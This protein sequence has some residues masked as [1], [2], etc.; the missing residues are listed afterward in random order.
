M[1]NLQLVKPQNVIQELQQA[2]WDIPFS[3]SAYQNTTFVLAEQLTP[4]RAYRALGLK[5]V[6]ILQAL[7]EATF[8]KQLAEVDIEELEET[9]KTSHNIYEKKRARIKISQKRESM[10]W[11]DKLMNDSLVEL[12]NLY[13]EFKKF[14]AYTRASFESEEEE[15]FKRKLSFALQGGEGAAGSLALVT[16]QTDLN[17]ELKKLLGGPKPG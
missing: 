7:Q 1:N 15:H 2:F 16:A 10:S 3:N 6:T 14:P 12:T 9:L 13:G 11:T 5:I 8:T 4:G 17:S